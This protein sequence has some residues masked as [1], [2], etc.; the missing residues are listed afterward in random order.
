MGLVILTVAALLDPILI[1]LAVLAAW[2]LGDIFAHRRWWTLAATCVVLAYPTSVIPIWVNAYFYSRV[3]FDEAM[4][5]DP[6]YDPFAEIEGTRYEDYGDRFTGV[7]NHNDTEMVMA[8]I[9][10]QT[11]KCEA[12]LGYRSRHFN[13]VMRDCRATIAKATLIATGLVLLLAASISRRRFI[14]N[15]NSWF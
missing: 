10:R 12:L 1:A 3:E 14:R 9:D 6:S 11:A 13:D 5:I 7:R 8:Q 15:G 4:P 2:P